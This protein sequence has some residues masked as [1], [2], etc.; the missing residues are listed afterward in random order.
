[1]ITI[2]K[3]NHTLQVSKDTYKT[4]FKR[5]GYIVVDNKEEIKKE[6]SS[7]S[8]NIKKDSNNNKES[9]EKSKDEKESLNNNLDDIFEMLSKD[10]NKKIGKQ[11]NKEEK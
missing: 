8:D 4:M 7:K 6:T 5:M 9:I 11:K 1:M 2:Q 3:G 10:D